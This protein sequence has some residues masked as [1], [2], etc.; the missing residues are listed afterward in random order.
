MTPLSSEKLCFEGARAP[1]LEKNH[2]QDPVGIAH[3]FRALFGL[4]VD[5]IRE[6][7]WSILELKML[8]EIKQNSELE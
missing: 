6:P 2:I 3:V 4:I 5:Q 7:I 8:L 1:Q